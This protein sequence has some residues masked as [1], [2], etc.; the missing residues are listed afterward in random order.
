MTLAPRREIERWRC[1]FEKSLHR[2][3]FMYCLVVIFQSA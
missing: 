3:T 1:C 2:R